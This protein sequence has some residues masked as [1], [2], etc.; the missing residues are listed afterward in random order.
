MPSVFATSSA[1]RRAREAT[2][3]TSIHSLVCIAGMTFL[4]AI[5]AV[6]RIPQRTFLPIP[7]ILEPRATEDT[8]HG[9]AEDEKICSERPMGEVLQIVHLDGCGIGIAAAIYL[10]Q[11][12]DTWAHGRT[13]GKKLRIE[14]LAVVVR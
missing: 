13:E 14:Q 7:G 1:L 5:P 12:C 9:A 10:P 3:V 4:T 11:A 8:G 6:L 2:A